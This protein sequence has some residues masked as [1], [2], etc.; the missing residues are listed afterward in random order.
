MSNIRKRFEA[1]LPD[2]RKS[3]AT[4]NS[5]RGD[6]TASVTSPAGNSYVVNTAGVSVSRRT[7]SLDRRHDDP[8]KHICLA[9]ALHALLYA[10]R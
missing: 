2:R 8:C 10:M 6:G 5:D 3:L 7:P 1:L 9:H 4:V